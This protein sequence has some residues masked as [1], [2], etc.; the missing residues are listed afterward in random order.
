MRRSLARQ[1][2]SCEQ[3]QHQR[4]KLGGLYRLAQHLAAHLYR[5]V[6]RI[7]GAI[8]RNDDG[9]DALVVRSAN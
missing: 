2:R 4:P 1:N 7:R 6:G 3:M 9:G 5:L 8:R